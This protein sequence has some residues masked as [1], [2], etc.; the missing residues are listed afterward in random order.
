MIIGIPF[1]CFIFG[2]ILIFIAMAED[3]TGDMTSFNCTLKESDDFSRDRKELMEHF[4]AAIQICSD[5]KQ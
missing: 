4:C 1:Y 2:T 5:V 3:I